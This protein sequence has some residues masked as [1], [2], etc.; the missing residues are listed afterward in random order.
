LSEAGSISAIVNSPAW[1]VKVPILPAVLTAVTLTFAPYPYLVSSA[2][3][4]RD[5]SIDQATASLAPATISAIPVNFSTLFFP[6]VIPSPR[7]NVTYLLFEL[8]VAATSVLPC[9]SLKF[10][11][12]FST[13]EL[14]AFTVI[15]LRRISSVAEPLT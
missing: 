3:I 2:D 12:S 1:I 7:L 10:V 4:S 5:L 15:L 9:K 6:I 11:K 14:S 8:G 13:F